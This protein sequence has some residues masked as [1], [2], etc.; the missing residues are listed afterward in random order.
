MDR[1][2]PTTPTN[3][4]LCYEN[5]SPNL[6]S[7]QSKVGGACCDG[8]RSLTDHKRESPV[9]IPFHHV[10]RP[11]LTRSLS[12]GALGTTMSGIQTGDTRTRLDFTGMSLANGPPQEGPEK[13]SASSTQVEPGT[14][15][16][17]SQD[18]AAGVWQEFVTPTASPRTPMN[19]APNRHL[20]AFTTEVKSESD[21][22]I[23]QFQAQL[24]KIG[25]LYEEEEEEEDIPK[26]EEMR[27]D[28]MR[29][30][31]ETIKEFMNDLVVKENMNPSACIAECA[32]AFDMM[33]RDLSHVCIEQILETF[34]TKMRKVSD[35]KCDEI[36]ESMGCCSRD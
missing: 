35:A 18:G 10:K 22:K 26:S 14:P 28:L 9:D 29:W 19:A 13:G 15:Q 16:V 23:E 4:L 6:P 1:A 34:K 2:P 3:E 7:R 36:H 8:I 24:R 20:Y 32:N 5:M 11:A 33:L 12:G 27:R 21:L 31:D 30:L 25:A 17:V